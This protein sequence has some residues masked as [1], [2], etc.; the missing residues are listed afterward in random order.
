MTSSRVHM[1]H[2][3][4]DTHIKPHVKLA[5]YIRSNRYKQAQTQCPTT[6]AYLA[7]AIAEAT[8]RHNVALEAHVR[9]QRVVL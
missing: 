4:A 9:T 1:T 2:A 5:M 3:E 8:H 6:K 7:H